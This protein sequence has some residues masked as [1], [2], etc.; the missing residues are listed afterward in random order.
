MSKR[1]IINETKSTLQYKDKYGV[2]VNFYSYIGG[3]KKLV[4]IKK[5]EHADDHFDE[6]SIKVSKHK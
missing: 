5:I 3:R 2:F 1:V 6:K 4:A